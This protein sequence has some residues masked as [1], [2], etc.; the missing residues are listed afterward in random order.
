M[1]VEHFPAAE[2]LGVEAD[3]AAAAEEF[4]DHA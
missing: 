4:G 3:H 2:G 1:D